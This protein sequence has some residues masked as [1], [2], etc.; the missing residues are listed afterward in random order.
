MRVRGGLWQIQVMTDDSGGGHL[1]RWI[2]NMKMADT[3]NS[4]V[5]LFKQIAQSKG[6]PLEALKEYGKLSAGGMLSS[7]GHSSP[8]LQVTPGMPGYPRA[9]LCISVAL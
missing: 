2:R 6:S 3:I 8:A 5:P 4:M 9:N 7:L 1:R